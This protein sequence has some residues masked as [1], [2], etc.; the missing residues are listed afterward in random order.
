MATLRK[1]NDLCLGLLILLAAVQPWIIGA[2]QPGADIDNLVDGE[3]NITG[4]IETSG[5]VGVGCNAP[6]L[7]ALAIAHN[8]AAPI[9]GAAASICISA[10]TSDGIVYF[11]GPNGAM[12]VGANAFVFKAFYEQNE[13]PTLSF[14][15]E[16]VFWK[17]TN[18]SDR[19]YLV[20][21]R[22]SGDQVKAEFT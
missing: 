15:G 1:H 18:D 6:A 2:Y 21:R 13:E 10:D 7:A 20:F 11:T 9:S 16:M 22:G 17:D 19:L 3:L 5:G 12:Y 14:D 4:E 8:A